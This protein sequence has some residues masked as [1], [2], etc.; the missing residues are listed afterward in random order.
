[1]VKSSRLKVGMMCKIF[2][3]WLPIAKSSLKDLA[4][5]SSLKKADEVHSK[6]G[7]KK[8]SREILVL[9]VALVTS[10]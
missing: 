10:P 5:L 1:M 6:K 8:S 3:G 2:S 7:V 4:K 9:K